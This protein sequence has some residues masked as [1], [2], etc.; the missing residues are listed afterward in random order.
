MRF[1]RWGRSAY[2][3]D[4]SLAHEARQVSAYL[5]P[6]GPSRDAEVVAVN[7]GTTVGA[8]FLAKVP[9]LRLLITTTSGFDHLDLAALHSAGV[10]VARAP[11]ARRDAVVDSALGL[12]LQ[13]LRAHGPLD[14]ASA[15]GRWAR[16]ELPELSMRTLRGARIGVVGLGVIGRRMADLL[17]VLGAT[18]VGCDPAG[19]PA[20]V[21]EASLE[22]MLSSCDGVTLH[23]RLEPGSD[24]LVDRAALAHTHPGLVLV[25][26]ARGGSLDVDAAVE[27]VQEGRLGFL[28][29]D[30]FPEEPWP[31]LSQ[32]THPRVCFLPH[33][34]GY[35]DGL[36]A[37]VADAV[38][39]AVAAFVAGEPQPHPVPPVPQSES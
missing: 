25:N 16:T 1:S 9:S 11:L 21:G 36:P 39:T 13:G 5:T 27:R 6:V 35:H 2:E 30:V 37:A 34:A 22:E 3:T 18:V 31:R 28:G 23:C 8:A 32:A 19:L 24:R 7:S 10:T 20:S 33:A 26:T 29:V 14:A 17:G 38:K 4:A 15:G 12:L